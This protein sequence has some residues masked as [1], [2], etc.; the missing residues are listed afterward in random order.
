MRVTDTV[1]LQ[2]TPYPHDLAVCSEESF[3]AASR[4]AHTRDMFRGHEVE[5]SSFVCKQ[6]KH[7]VGTAKSVREKVLGHRTDIGLF[8]CHSSDR[9]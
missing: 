6:R 1:F 8:I 7:V 4:S 5:R 9:H 2:K 3:A